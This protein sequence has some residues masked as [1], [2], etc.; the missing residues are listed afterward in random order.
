M[1][2]QSRKFRET[3]AMQADVVMDWQSKMHDKDQEIKLVSVKYEKKL[4]SMQ[5]EL[6]ERDNSLEKQS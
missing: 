3:E 6:E 5:V 1:R 4:K 2:S